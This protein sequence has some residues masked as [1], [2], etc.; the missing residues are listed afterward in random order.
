MLDPPEKGPKLDPLKVGLPLHYAC[1]CMQCIEESVSIFLIQLANVLVVSDMCI[2]SL[3]LPYHPLLS[4]LRG[5]ALLLPLS[6]DDLTRVCMM[7]II[8]TKQNEKWFLTICD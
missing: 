1:Y 2:R 7:Y 6:L 5:Q 3:A 4:S 8:G